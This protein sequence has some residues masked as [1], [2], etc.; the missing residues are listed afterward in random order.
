MNKIYKFGL[1]K[2]D[3]EI[4]YIYPDIWCREDYGTWSRITVAPSNNHIGLILEL[5]KKMKPPYG[6]LYV[7]KLS[8]SYLELRLEE[9][10]SIT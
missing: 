4:E 8:R 10:R 2:E 9:I 6:I 5:L 3:I 1:L 7:L